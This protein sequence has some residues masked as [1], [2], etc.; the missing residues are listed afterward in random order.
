LDLY[1]LHEPTK[2]VLDRLEEK[3]FFMGSATF[4]KDDTPTDLSEL[5]RES[6]YLRVKELEQNIYLLQFKI[7][8]LPRKGRI[9]TSKFKDI[10]NIFNEN[11]VIIKF[12]TYHLPL[13]IP[14]FEHTS[15]LQ[16]LIRQYQYKKDI[17]YVFSCKYDEG[18]P[19]DEQEHIESVEGVKVPISK[20]IKRIRYYFNNRN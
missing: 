18:I 5:M 8:L 11:M 7:P 4:H 3:G 20:G 2:T 19:P 12:G 1:L 6:F 16:E 9:E 17:L 15:D 10:P 13:N 14:I